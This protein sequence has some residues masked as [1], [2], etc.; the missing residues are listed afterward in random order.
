MQAEETKTQTKI[1]QNVISECKTKLLHFK[2][3]LLNRFVAHKL[4][5]DTAEKSGDEVDQAVAALYENS[6]L[7]THERM[8]AQLS[9]IEHALARIENGSFGICE[10]T[11]EVIE[12]ERLLAIPWT[13]LS[14]EGAELR[15]SFTNR[16]ARR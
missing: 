5:F 6:F 8:R 11:E 3:D 12:T 15:E 16:H 2:Q 13:R 14:I 10:E 7:I 4:T 1:D 9:E